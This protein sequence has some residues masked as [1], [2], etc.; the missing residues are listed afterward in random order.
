MAYPRLKRA[1]DVA[2]AGLGLVALAPVIA[3]VAG[4]VL[5]A[6]GAPV[7]FTQE[8]VTQGNRIFRLKKFRSMR[9]FDPERGW[10]SD[11]ARL[12]ALGRFIRA[13]SLDELPSLWNIL[14][15]DMSL[16]G[17]RPLTTEYLPLYTPEQ[18]RRHAV[19]G[20]LS[21]LAQ[22]SGRNALSWDERFDLDV[23]YVETMSLRTD[24]RILLRTVLTVF[25]REGVSHPGSAT[26]ISFG[27]SMRSELVEFEQIAR[28]R[29]LTQWMARTRN[30]ERVGLCEMVGTGE[31]ARII[32]FLPHPT[33]PA[34]DA[35]EHESLC[36]EVMRL[37]L[38]RVRA[39][40]ADYAFC[41][42]S[43]AAGAPHL[44]LASG[45]R[46]VTGS[47]GTVPLPTAGTVRPGEEY[48]C[49]S[50]RSED[51]PTTELRMAS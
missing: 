36:R 37:L 31:S 12:T 47:L 27:G 25:R 24:L 1:I 46:P 15:G 13:T 19:R 39:A 32:R 16:I 20:G 2:G 3:V 9:P 7:I 50:L 35:D 42:A 11:S 14:V 33:N 10:T 44:Y 29:E 21:G 5:V 38:N 34:F 26:M 43:T 18:L 4:L 51:R 22:V 41:P 28:T 17:P 45:F 30:G 23:E 8:R 48:L 49:C 6:H 40:D